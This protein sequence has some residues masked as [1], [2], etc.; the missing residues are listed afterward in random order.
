[1]FFFLFHAVI[2][3]SCVE[4][5]MSLRGKWLCRAARRITASLRH[6]QP[7]RPR[8]FLFPMNLS[9]IHSSDCQMLWLLET[10]SSSR[11]SPLSLCHLWLVVVGIMNNYTSVHFW[12]VEV[13]QVGWIFFF[14]EGR[15]RWPH[16]WLTVGLTS[17]T[18]AT[19]SCRELLW[20]PSTPLHRFNCS[21]V[22]MSFMLMAQSQFMK[23]YY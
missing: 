19:V 2:I 12:E 14:F 7:Y 4:P 20:L 6:S 9:V 3:Q 16:S 18:W 22:N 10:M 21:S 8:L 23:F 11:A 5:L 17:S 13:K 15:Q 1:M